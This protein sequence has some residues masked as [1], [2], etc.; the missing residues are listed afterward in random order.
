[1]NI[2]KMALNNRTTILV[3]T[4]VFFLGG[5]NTFNNLSWLENPEF[6][7]KQALIVTQYPGASAA[8]VEEEITDE[9]EI[10]IQQLGQLSEVESKSER[11]V[12]TV[13]V[14]IKDQ[15]DKTTLPQVWDELRR[16]INDV[17]GRLP[18]GAGASIVLDDY[19]D[20]F[21]IFIAIS[22]SEYSHTELQDFADILRRELLLVED[23]AKVDFWG[24]RQEAIYVEPERDRFSQLGIVPDQILQSLQ[25]RNIVSDSGR[26]KVGREYVPIDP[27]GIFSNVSEIGNLAI[28]SQTSGQQ[29]YLR[30]VANVRR[31]YVEPRSQILRFNG[32]PSL[33]LGISATSGGNVVAMGNAVQARLQELLPQTP[34]GIELNAISMQSEAVS[35]SI[36]G[37]VVSLL[38]AVAIVIVVL[39]A[40]MGLRS[41]LLIGFVLVVTIAATFIFMGLF[42]VALERISLGALIIALGMLVDNA[43]VVVDGMLVRIQ[44]GMPPTA[45]AEEVVKQ[46]AFPLFGATAVAIMAFGAVG[47]SDDATGEFC[48]SLFQ[49]VLISLSLSWVIAVTLTP[50]LGV[51]LLGKK[52]GDV[53]KSAADPYANSFY[54]AYRKLL[55][56]CIRGRWITLSVVLVGF[57]LSI[58]GFG[59]VN[60]SFFP[61]STRP[62]FKVDMW[63]PQGTHIDYTEIAAA[64][65]ERYLLGL[66]ETTKVTSLIG[67]GGMRFML[68]YNPEQPNSAYAQ[69]LVDVESHE[70]IEEIIP[71][72]EE[73]L[74]KLVPDSVVYAKRF[75]L[76]PGSAPIKIRISGPDRDR[77]RGL[78]A[79]VESVLYQD[80]G[81]RAIRTDWRQRTKLIQPIMALDEANRAGI[82]RTDLA[83]VLKYSF[84]GQTSGVYR[85]GDDL[86]PI[87][88]RASE[89]EQGDAA[90][91]ENIQLFSPVAGHN[92]GIS[93]VVAGFETVYEDEIIYRLNRERT[94]SIE[95]EPLNI[96]I[97]VLF[98]RVRPKVEAIELGDGYSL[99]WWGE[100]RDTSRAQAGIAASLPF[101]FLSMVIIVIALFNSLKQPLII[102]ATVPLALIGVTAGLLITD[103]PFGFMALLGFMSLSGMLIKNAIVL[104]DE[105]ESQKRRGIEQLLAIVESGVS[106]L[107]PV[108]MAALTTALGM[109]PLVFDAFFVSMAVTIIFGLMVATLLTMLFVPVLYAILFKAE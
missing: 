61:E 70:V 53:N 43:I 27:T 94:I 66:P 30:D 57:S 77:L 69:F 6:T 36:E 109:I 34:L 108:A 37:F 52:S 1:L 21:G 40:F 90:S 104:I 56:S 22:G 78:S 9:I 13:T 88:F 26:V 54:M 105:I 64:E 23:V 74:K 50:V 103:Q 73:N 101:F 38:E 93:Q 80:G 72:I 7:I 62:Q 24:Q 58:W 67:A 16:K 8:E 87:I 98:E 35:S 76:G 51:M 47:L 28:S 79:E 86:I 92:L 45:A 19:S 65:A 82:G 63:F 11:G 4:A 106:R 102:W 91:I 42:N 31:G 83:S 15:Y 14:T 60:Q 17:Q 85:E 29:I 20:V 55:E 96:P 41:G 59:F 99:E 48:R 75:N 49:V 32:E 18:P 10:A 3:L 71:A 46:T 25:D 44:K 89:P 39:L 100:Y 12:S 5:I 2:A 95:A 33:G 81:A 97:S 107:R 84:E 68:T